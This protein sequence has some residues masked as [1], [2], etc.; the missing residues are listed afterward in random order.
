[1]RRVKASMAP[2]RG[3]IPGR[4]ADNM[5]VVR[6]REAGNLIDEV[7]SIEEGETRIEEYEKKD[8]EEGTYE[9]D[10]YE[11]VEIKETETQKRLGFYAYRTK[12]TEAQKR[13]SNRYDR[14][15]TKA[16]ALKLNKK[17]DADI[18][19]KLE[20]VDNVQGYIKALIRADMSENV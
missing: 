19:A 9:P 4:K 14:A 12:T 15:N 3:G 20:S 11:V 10:F 5:I 16:V 7:K 1:M 6:D 13:A 2:S 18:L 8:K 17:T